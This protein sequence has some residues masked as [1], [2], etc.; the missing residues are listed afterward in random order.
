M[1]DNKSDTDS[2]E[3]YRF[4][5]IPVNVC[6]WYTSQYMYITFPKL[7][8]PPIPCDINT[9]Q[10][11]DFVNIG[12]VDT[13]IWMRIVAIG[14]W[15]RQF[16]GEPFSY[17]IGPSMKHL[18]MKHYLMVSH[19]HILRFRRTSVPNVQNLRQHLDSMTN[20]VEDDLDLIYDYQEIE[21][22]NTSDFV[23]EDDDDYDEYLSTDE[24]RQRD[25]S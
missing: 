19:R 12:N 23:D 15:D 3:S 5:G 25:L 6:D 1:S 21:D 11:G 18:N 17:A 4:N 9:L 14:G 8:E 13:I 20:T 2:L 24:C 22:C 10:V 16:I 7:Y